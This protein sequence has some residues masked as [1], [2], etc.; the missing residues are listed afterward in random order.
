MPS[1]FITVPP[2]N[3]G[4]FWGLDQNM[5]DIVEPTSGVMNEIYS[6][7]VKTASLS[8]CYIIALANLKSFSK[9]YF[10]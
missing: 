4:R 7:S 9:K 5:V 8:Q 6:Y 2:N 10:V 1:A 3:Q